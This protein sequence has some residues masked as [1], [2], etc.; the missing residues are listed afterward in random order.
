[1][2]QKKLLEKQEVVDVIEFAQNLWAAE[3]Y[4][5]YTPWLQNQLLN[6]LNN[7]PRIPDYKSIVEALSSYKESAKNLQ[8]YMEFMQKF[9][10]IF[11]RTLMSYVNVLSFDLTI[12]CKNAFTQADYQ[13][14]EYAEDKKRIYKF[15]DNFDYKA[16]F[17]KMLQEMLRH[18]VVYTWFRKT[19]WGNKGMKCALQILPQNRCMLTGY[20][21]KG[22]LFDFDMNYFLQPGV[23]IDGFDPEFKKYYNNVFGTTENPWRYVP[24][25]PLSSRDGTFAMW[26]QTSPDSG[27]W[28]WKFD[29]S[30]FNTTPYLAPFLK[31][32]IR[33]DEIAILQYN[34]DIA[35]AYGILAGEIKTFDN[36]KSG[37]VANQFTIDPALIGVLMG[38]VKQGL[39]G[40]G[41]KGDST[42]TTKAVAMPVENIK[43]FQFSDSNPTMYE[44]QLANSAGVGSGISRVIYSSDRMSNAEIEAGIIDQY[45]TVKQVYSQFNNF[46]EFF[47]N[48]LTKKYKFKFSFDGC[49][50]PFEREKRFERLTKAADKGIVL[51]P[52][53]WASAMGYTP[54]EFDRLLDEAKYG[55]F[56][57]KWQLMLNTNTT[58]QESQG[59]RPRKDDGDLTD[60]G[61]SS[62]DGING[63]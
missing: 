33:N 18:E 2:A 51:G 19:K 62:R 56:S 44:Q 5:L 7:N 42:S 39:Q 57:N 53:A 30:N 41:T 54:M 58:A 10:M 9:D 63:L 27:A 38:K 32:A 34:K 1:M 14:A 55:D 52:S 35:S 16:E 13:S 4:G 60:S 40:I 20:W 36:A 21:E 3:K 43:W 28:V 37:T 23:D 11:A 47:G 22:M 17:R 25:N 6:N 15:L 50:Y 48:Q 24:T 61:E 49:S 46:L 29:M 45:N 26:T 8:D 59:G 12:T 31:D